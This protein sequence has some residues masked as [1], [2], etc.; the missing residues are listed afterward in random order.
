MTAEPF[1][2]E[3]ESNPHPRML[4]EALA[5]RR[6]AKWWKPW[7]ILYWRGYFDAMVGATGCDPADMHAWVESKA[8]T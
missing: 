3:L 5:A 4:Q 2:L 7:R 6:A 1:V 8:E